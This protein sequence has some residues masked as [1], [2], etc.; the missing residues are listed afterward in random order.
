MKKASLIPRRAVAN[1][2]RRAATDDYV[3]LEADSASSPLTCFN[4]LRHE[5]STMVCSVAGRLY[6]T[7]TGYVP[8][9]ISQEITI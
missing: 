6:H 5:S 4:P 2:A 8:A 7:S 3:F 9:L 1:D